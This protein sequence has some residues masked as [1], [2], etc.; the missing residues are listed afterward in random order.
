MDLRPVLLFLEERAAI[1]DTT[2]NEG[3]ASSSKGVAAQTFLTALGVGIAASAGQL[4][5]FELIR[6]KLTR[7]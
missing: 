3:V 7:I 6:N 2:G 4:M 5:V 1:N